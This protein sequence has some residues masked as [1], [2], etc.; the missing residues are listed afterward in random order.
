MTIADSEA[1]VTVHEVA[2]DESAA[3]FA[4]ACKR[5]LEVSPAVFLAAYESGNLPPEWHSDDISRVEFLLPFAS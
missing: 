3:L 1:S 2:E 5:Y 4:E